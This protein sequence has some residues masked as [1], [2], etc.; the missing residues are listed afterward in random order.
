MDFYIDMS[1]YFL[2]YFGWIIYH[3]V[4]AS[5]FNVMCGID[6]IPGR[7]QRYFNEEKLVRSSVFVVS[8]AVLMRR[9]QFFDFLVP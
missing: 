4:E 3:G 9:Y 7:V 5:K 8:Q 6:W 1:Y 2:A